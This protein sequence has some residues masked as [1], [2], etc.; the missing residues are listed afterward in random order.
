M[1][2]L[3]QA[4]SNVHN[5]P[6]NQWA[7]KSRTRG[8]GEFNPYAVLKWHS[9][10][11]P[12]KLALVTP[13]AKYTFQELEVLAGKIASKL[14]FHGVRPGH[15]IM[16]ALPKDAAWIFQ[17]AM[18]HDSIVSMSATQ[19]AELPQEHFVD[20]ILATK[21]QKNLPLDRIIVIDGDWVNDAIFKF[22]PPKEMHWFQ[23]ENSLVRVFPTSGSTGKPKLVPFSAKVFDVRCEY[24]SNFSN[25]QQ[26]YVSILGMSAISGYFPCLRALFAGETCYLISHNDPR[27][28]GFL[29]EHRALTLWGSP[30]QMRGLLKRLPSGFE[31]KLS[32]D[33]ILTSGSILPRELARKLVERFS[34]RVRNVYGSTETS[35][36][37]SIAVDGE[38]DPAIAGSVMSD[39]EVRIFEEDKGSEV[40]RGSVGLVG[41][42]SP[43]MVNQYLGNPTATAEFFKG[44]WFFSGDLG[45][46]D[47]AGRLVLSGRSSEIVNVGGVKV[48]PDRIDNYLASH[49]A[50]RDGAAFAVKDEYGMDLMIAGVVPKM[51]NLDL[52]GLTKDMRAA[53]GSQSAIFAI[54]VPE[55]PRNENGKVVRYKLSERYQKAISERLKSVKKNRPNDS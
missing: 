23:D 8:E 28:W 38:V 17:L 44:G 48:N 21:T 10:N 9:S 31:S 26:P 40:Q 25:Y 1:F 39:S 5:N 41:V 34:C 52:K 37:T 18:F 3:D 20:W 30:L 50:I 7:W 2:S 51:K 6:N 46:L 12:Q 54:P 29:E 16:I 32:L 13:D 42:R 27:L 4:T 45:F 36:V 19:S 24:E 35:G 14:R 11:S 33:M 53:L 47:D 22:K 55:I 43:S 49:P 15:T